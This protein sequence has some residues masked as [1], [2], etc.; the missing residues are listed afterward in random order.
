MVGAI[1]RYPA[2]RLHSAVLILLRGGDDTAPVNYKSCFAQKRGLV[3]Q[4]KDI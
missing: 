4:P 1:L 2:S 3:V